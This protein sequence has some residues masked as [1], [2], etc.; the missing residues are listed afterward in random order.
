MNKLPKV[1][2]LMPTYNRNNFLSKG[3][4]RVIDTLQKYLENSYE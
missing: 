2:I 1:S 3:K 4:T